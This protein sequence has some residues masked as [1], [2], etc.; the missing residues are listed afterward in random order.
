[1]RKIKWSNACLLSILGE[2]QL[3]E[4]QNCKA[5]L[6]LDLTTLNFVE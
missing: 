4:T 6:D 5:I 2:K 3:Q 1:M